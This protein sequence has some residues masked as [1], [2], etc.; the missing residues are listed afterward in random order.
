[1]NKWLELVLGLLLV[2][3]PLG[4]AL[5]TWPTWWTSAL[6]V[7]IGGLF[8]GLVGLGVLFLLLGIADV[9]G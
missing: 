7:L 6:T 8:W 9:K 1:M 2:T 5:S 3:I 4:L